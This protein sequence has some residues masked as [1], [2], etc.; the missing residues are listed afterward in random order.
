MINVFLLK[1]FIFIYLFVL[2]HIFQ[3]YQFY[4]TTIFSLIVRLFLSA[5]Y[6]ATI[7]TFH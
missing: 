4:H 3:Y 6:D 7:N 2:G 5:P 1:N